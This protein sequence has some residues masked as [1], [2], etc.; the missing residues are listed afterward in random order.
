[1]TSK[2]NKYADVPGWYKNCLPSAQV[3]FVQ[4]LIDKFKLNKN[5]FEVPNYPEGEP[6]ATDDGVLMLDI[7]LPDEEMYVEPFFIR[8][9]GWKRTLEQLWYELS[10]RVE[11]EYLWQVSHKDAAVKA[12]RKAQIYKANWSTRPGV[13]W[14]RFKLDYD[15]DV[16]AFEARRTLVDGGRVLATSSVLL[17]TLYWPDW[18]MGWRKFGHHEPLLANVKLGRGQRRTLAL[19]L[20]ESSELYWENLSHKEVS[21][22]RGCPTV[23]LLY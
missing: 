3:L 9:E 16:S 14:V 22:G 6:F 15:S 4:Y 11:E 10:D 13:R 8:T 12:L 23:S 2:A 19:G 18:V 1:M 20:D 7:V 21:L 5:H 17:A